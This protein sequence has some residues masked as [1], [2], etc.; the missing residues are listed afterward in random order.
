MG[1]AGEEETTDL[2]SG[3]KGAELLKEATQ[4]GMILISV[5]EI[6]RLI[7]TS[8]NR[9]PNAIYDIPFLIF[10]FIKT[11]QKIIPV[12]YIRHTEMIK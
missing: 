2:P 4:S 9:K 11:F 10:C 12:Y 6:V 3:L 1:M 7:F 8:V 5:P